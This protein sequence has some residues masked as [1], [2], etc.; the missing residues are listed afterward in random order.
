M[1]QEAPEAAAEK[2]AENNHRFILSRTS[3]SKRRS[4]FVPPNLEE[5]C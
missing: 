3:A 2:E 1:A 4:A 5:H